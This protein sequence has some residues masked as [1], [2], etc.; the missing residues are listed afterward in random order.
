M[1]RPAVPYDTNTSHGAL[2]A[3]QLILYL[4]LQVSRKVYVARQ[5][6]TNETN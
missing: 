2:D 4:G 6:I 3:K 5:R 1:K